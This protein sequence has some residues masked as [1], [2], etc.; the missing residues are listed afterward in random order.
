V[1]S[2]G[3]REGRKKHDT[4]IVAVVIEAQ[5]PLEPPEKHTECPSVLS[6]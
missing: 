1:R 4:E 6:I 5:F 2:L 3:D